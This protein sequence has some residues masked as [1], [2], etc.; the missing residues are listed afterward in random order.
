MEALYTFVNFVLETHDV[1]V[2]LISVDCGNKL[3]EYTTKL[4]LCEID[5][6]AIFFVLE[7]KSDSWQYYQ[8]VY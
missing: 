5:D 4:R 8:N 6:E 7:C 2:F 1:A 3:V